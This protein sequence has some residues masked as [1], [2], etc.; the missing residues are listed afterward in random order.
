ML[1]IST[2]GNSKNIINAANVAK[3]K[4]LKIIS[5]TNYF[6]GTLKSVSHVNV[7]VPEIQTFKTQELHLPIYHIISILIEESFFGLILK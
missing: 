6:G 7:N 3:F 4:N 5:F 2:S 1:C